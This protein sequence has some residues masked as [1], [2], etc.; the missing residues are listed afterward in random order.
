M[1]CSLSKKKEKEHK[2][3]QKPIQGS[4]YN[5]FRLLSQRESPRLRRDSKPI[6]LDDHLM[7]V[8]DV[9]YKD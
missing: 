7:D 2:K 3:P 8:V 9:C 5:I 6:D 4:I 1:G